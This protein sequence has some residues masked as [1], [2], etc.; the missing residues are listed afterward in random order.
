MT[1]EAAQRL[2]KQLRRIVR[3]STGG[4][5]TLEA[6]VVENGANGAEI[7]FT[8]GRWGE[9]AIGLAVSDRARVLAHWAGYVE[10]HGRKALPVVGMEVLFPSASAW[11]AGGYRRGVVTRVGMSRVTIAYRFAHG[12]EGKPTERGIGEIIF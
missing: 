5:L 6:R 9:H 7:V 8:G 2:A 1:V 4:K 11:R 12:G 3:P 10:A